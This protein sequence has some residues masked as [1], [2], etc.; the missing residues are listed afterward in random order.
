MH[1]TLHHHIPVILTS[2]T[3]PSTGTIFPCTPWYTESPCASYPSPS[4][5]CHLY[6]YYQSIYRYIL[7]FRVTLC[8]L[9]FSLHY[10]IP[11]HH[12][13]RLSWEIESLPQTQG[14][15]KPQNLEWKLHQIKRK[16]NKW[17]K[18]IE[19]IPQILIF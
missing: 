13:W 18:G 12:H 19:S 11:L 3:N 1:P 4:Y 2:T 16:A 8:I 15:I 17:K 9:P 14:I 6:I 7:I 10:N 5:L